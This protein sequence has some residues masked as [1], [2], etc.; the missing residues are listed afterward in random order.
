MKKRTH[1][2]QSPSCLAQAT[3]CRF[4]PDFAALAAPL[5]RTMSPKK[6]SKSIDQLLTNHI[7]VFRGDKF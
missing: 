4:A 3:R 2:K 1:P 7:P 6:Q 5:R